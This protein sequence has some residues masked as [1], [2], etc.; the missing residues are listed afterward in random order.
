MRIGID[1]SA[2]RSG[3][4]LTHLVEIIGALNP[5][6]HG[7]ERVIVWSNGRTLAKLPERPWLD[8]RDEPLLNRS[9]PFRIF[10]Q[11]FRLT[12]L[13]RKSCDL[14]F[15]PSATYSG[16]FRPYVTMFRNLL[17]FDIPERR[18]FR[19]SFRYLRYLILERTQ[20]ASMKRA[21]GV[22]FLSN[23]ARETVT[24]R[25]GN[26]R[27]EV[28]MIPHGIS[29]RFRQDAKPAERTE[30][31]KG[32]IRCLYVSIVNLYKHQWHVCEAIA[33]LRNE[34]IPVELDLVG[35]AYAPALK[36]LNETLDRVDPQRKFIRYREAV[37]YNELHIL[38]HNADI[39]I[40]ASSC[41]NLPNI[42]R[43]AMASG[44]PIACSR[45]GPM[46]EVL[47]DAGV[48]FDPEQPD[49]IATAVRQ[50]IQ[51][52]DLRRTCARKALEY[53]SQFSW[54]RCAGETFS[55]LASVASNGPSTGRDVAGA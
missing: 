45:R 21:S 51:S 46:P 29:E 20:A 49:D 16:G 2:I 32:V 53:A 9:L 40:F 35:P 31:G 37:P 30:Q 17:P 23:V 38:Y 18:R 1:A 27:G 19:P 3:G 14:L 41:E 33:R 50:L 8:R 54:E 7:I 52:P 24:A 39:F 13:A 4:A 22:I 34:G 28:A 47:G 43:E 44:L 55:F 11:K 26:L 42:L 25:I 36:R 6:D 12:R 10:W 48:Y 5:G 15:V